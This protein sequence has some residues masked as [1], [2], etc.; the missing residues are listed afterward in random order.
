MSTSSSSE[1]ELQDLPE[2]PDTTGAY[3]RLTD[4]QIMLLSQSGERK[5]LPKGTLL[6]CEGDRDCGL[7]VVL[8]GKVQVVQEGSTEGEARVLAVHG[9]G[10]FVGDLS[11]LTG[12]GVYVTAVAQT[13]VDVVEVS[14]DRLKEAVTQGPGPQVRRRLQHPWRGDLAHPG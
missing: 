9:R 8:D 4:E 10:C 6:F 2:T 14:Y 12:Q 1:L 5:R 7:F 3:P 13:D 11:I